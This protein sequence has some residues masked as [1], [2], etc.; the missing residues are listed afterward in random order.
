MGTRICIMSGGR[1]VQVGAPLDV[2]R[3]PTNTF[4][5]GFLGNPPM[6]LLPA[7]ATDGPEG[8]SIRVGA[9]VIALPP[10][11]TPP[12]SPGKV[13]TLGVRPEDVSNQPQ[14]VDRN[15]DVPVEVLQVERLGAETIAIARME[16]IERP[17]VARIGGDAAF[18]IGER[19]ALH[20]DRYAV[21][22]F[23]ETGDA[24][25]PTG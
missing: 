12:L 4:V 7:V 25:R 5:A 13:L 3:A 24:L 22:I 2:Y 9:N 14:A 10:E 19:R 20:L 11:R 1:V 17:I 21:H 6:N 8:R 18:G 15:I 23:D 16:G